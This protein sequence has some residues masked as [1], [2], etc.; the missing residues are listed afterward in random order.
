MKIVKKVKEKIESDI[1]YELDEYCCEK[2]RLHLSIN[3]SPYSRGLF[4]KDDK[5]FITTRHRPQEDM[6]D[7]G[8]YYHVRI[9]YCPF[10]GKRIENEIVEKKI[11]SNKKGLKYYLCRR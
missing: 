6:Y 4:T 7:D 11:K 8:D 2:M 10:C 1:T 9:F 5:V 3:G